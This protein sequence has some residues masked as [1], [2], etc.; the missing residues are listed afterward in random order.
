MIPELQ[1][2]A[3][4]GI[5]LLLIVFLG[6]LGRRNPIIGKRI[7]ILLLALL[8]QLVSDT[9]TYFHLPLPEIASQGLIAMLLMLLAIFL[10][11]VLKEFFLAWLSAKGVKVSKLI[12]DVSV[13]LIYVIPSWFCSRNSSGST[14][15]RCWPPRRC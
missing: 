5:L 12:T 9:V 14:S 15:P 6:L 10:V 7:G 11:S 4:S 8:V 1:A 2:F 13:A 3:S